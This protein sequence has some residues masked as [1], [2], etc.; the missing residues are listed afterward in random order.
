MNALLSLRWLGLAGLLIAV[1]VTGC[2]K[3]GPKMAPVSGTVTV[4]GVP[5]TAGQVTFVPVDTAEKP[6]NTGF[7]GGT[8]DATGKYTIFTGG[9]AGAPLGKY[10]A[11]VNPSMVPMA[12]GGAPPTAFNAK[13]RDAKTSTLDVEVVDGAP[14][15]KY[16]LKLTKK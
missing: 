13:F 16:D 8:L 9:E 2:G 6:G 14:A 3:A 12:G 15:G 4:D 10:K 5:L 11:T 7:S 1:A